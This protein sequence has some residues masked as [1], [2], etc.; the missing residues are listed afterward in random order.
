MR[1]GSLVIST[2]RGSIHD[3]EALHA[4]LVSG[5]LAGAGLDV[6]DKEPPAMTHPLLSHPAVVA[7]PH[8]AGVTHES[9]ERVGRMAAE[10]FAAAAAGDVPP[11]MLNPAALK[12]YS[13]RWSATFGRAWPGNAATTAEIGKTV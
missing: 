10:A 9:R 3:E 8:T 13:E 5:H 1:K 2:A 4:A 12:R 6:W 11:R 7:S